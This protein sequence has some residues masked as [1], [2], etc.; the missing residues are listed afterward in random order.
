ME[1]VEFE[2]NLKHI[3]GKSTDSATTATSNFL[4]WTFPTSFLS[5][6]ELRET[7]ISTIASVTP[8]IFGQNV[9]I[10]TTLLFAAKVPKILKLV[11][12]LLRSLL[13]LV[14]ITSSIWCNR[15]FVYDAIV[16]QTFIAF[17]MK[18]DCKFAICRSNVFKINFT[19]LEC[20][21]FFQNQENLRIKQII[22]KNRIS[23]NLS[24]SLITSP[25]VCFPKSTIREF[26]TG[27]T[28]GGIQFTGTS[29]WPFGV[30]K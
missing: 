18:F 21:R 23:H 16:V 19:L 20:Y 17:V 25:T 8:G 3:T 1:K 2:L 9:T 6:V 15:N 22:W 11:F 30:L 29:N 14:V 4:M 27:S 26:M 12:Y 28:L 24:L 13:S 5:F 10:I 7:L